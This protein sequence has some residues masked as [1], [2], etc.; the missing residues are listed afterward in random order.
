M[1]PFSRYFCFSL[2]SPKHPNH[3]PILSSSRFEKFYF[4]VNIVA[5]MTRAGVDFCYSQTLLVSEKSMRKC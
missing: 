2:F 4:K 5:R 1:A 3:A